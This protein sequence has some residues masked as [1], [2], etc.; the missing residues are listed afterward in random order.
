MWSALDP[1]TGKILW[2]TAE[3]T[4]SWA[5]GPVSV[6]NGV[7]YAGAMDPKGYMRALDAATGKILWSFASG[8]A[9][10]SGPAIADG[11]VFWGSGYEHLNSPTV[12]LSVGN[13]MFYAFAL[14]PD[15]AK[16]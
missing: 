11:M 7:V 15:A 3:P 5:W 4:G 16:H 12:K 1:A 6:A 14:S 9:V 8:G 2:Q 13:N 10:A